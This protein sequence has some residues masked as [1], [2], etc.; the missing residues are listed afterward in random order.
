MIKK[1]TPSEKLKLKARLRILDRKLNEMYR[2]RK[3]SYIYMREQKEKEFKK[4]DD[5]RKEVRNKLK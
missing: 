3:Y 1:V 2:I 4:L 5:K